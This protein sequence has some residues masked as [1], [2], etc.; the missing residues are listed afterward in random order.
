[1]NASSAPRSATTRSARHR[2][3]W[4]TRTAL[5][6]TTALAC[7][8]ALAAPAYAFGPGTHTEITEGALQGFQKKSLEAMA[9]GDLGDGTWGAIRGSDKGTY[10]PYQTRYHCDDADYLKGGHYPRT[11]QQATGEL[12]ACVQTAV[13]EFHKAVVAA[14]G[15]VD[16]QGGINTKDVN[17]S[18]RCKYNDQPGRAKCE[19]FEHLGRAWHVIEDFYSHSNW[20]DHSDPKQAIGLTNPPGLQ[21]TT[22][23]PFFTLR[24]YSNQSTATWE[25]EATKEIDKTPDLAT[26]CAPQEYEHDDPTHYNDCTGRINHYDTNGKGG[27]SKEGSRAT[28]DDNGKHAVDVATEDIK[29]QWKDFQAELLATYP[30]GRG[31]K[32]ICALTHDTPTDATCK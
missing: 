23:A 4:H 3:P 12:L 9:A 16:S 18:S 6:I 22:P 14:D 26:G 29:R 28:I 13:E 17:L 30:H 19:V 24:A 31:T 25:A 7:L 21:K 5:A 32:M 2:R 1:M 8:P 10:Y 15:L 20:T 27:L 11:R